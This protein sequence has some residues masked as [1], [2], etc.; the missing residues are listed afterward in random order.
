MCLPISFLLL[1]VQLSVCGLQFVGENLQVAS[2]FILGLELF[3]QQHQI[4]GGVVE[5]NVA[6]V[7]PA[8]A[9]TQNIQKNK[10]QK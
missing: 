3:T 9:R 2:E 4:S 5:G 6:D 8:P 10:R 7:E 1:A